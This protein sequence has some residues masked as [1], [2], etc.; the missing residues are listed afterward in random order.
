MNMFGKVWMIHSLVFILSR[1]G[2]IVIEGGL[3][4]I[5]YLL[6]HQQVEFLVEAENA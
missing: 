6:V 4:Y 5:H 2:S 1:F 3:S